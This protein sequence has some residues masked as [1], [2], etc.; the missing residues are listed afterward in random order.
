MYMDQLL[1]IMFPVDQST[2]K[3]CQ[4][5]PYPLFFSSLIT[6]LQFLGEG[7]LKGKSDRLMVL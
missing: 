4:L 3:N 7:S 1:W 2:V 5:C 6:H